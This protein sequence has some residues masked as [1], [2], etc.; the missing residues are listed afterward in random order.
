MARW[1]SGQVVRWVGG[2]VD[3]WPGRSVAR[4]VRGPQPPDTPGN[5][6][7]ATRPFSPA[8]QQP[9]SGVQSTVSYEP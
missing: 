6:S 1:V 9:R 2:P 7:R 3:R 4:Q 5:P 8:A